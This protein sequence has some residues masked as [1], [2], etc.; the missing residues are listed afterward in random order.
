[1]DGGREGCDRGSIVYQEMKGVGASACL[2]IVDG[3][4]SRITKQ[5][6]K[7]R[8]NLPSRTWFDSLPFFFSFAREIADETEDSIES[9]GGY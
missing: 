5:S 9:H 4:E 1:M 3:E 6:S 2:R 7:R 8:K